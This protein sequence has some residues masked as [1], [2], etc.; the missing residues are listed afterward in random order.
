LRS[1]DLDIV[2]GAAQRFFAGFKTDYAVFGVG[3]IDADG[4]LLD[5]DPDEVMAREA[6]R[7]NCR[8]SLLVADAAKF[9]RSALARGGRLEQLDLCFVDEAPPAP[10]AALLAAQ[11]PRFHIANGVA[12]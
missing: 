8:Q 12:A 5:F 6:Q 2:G 3:G 1:N 4:T 10:H 9:G 11:R 7:E